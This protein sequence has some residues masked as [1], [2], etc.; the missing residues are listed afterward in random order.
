[1]TTTLFE[2]TLT[3]AR[4]LTVHE[5][6][7]LI[8]ALAEVLAAQPSPAAP[9]ATLVRLEAFRREMESLGPDAPN[10][11]AALEADRQTRQTTLEG[12]PHVHA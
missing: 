2:Q 1:M 4:Q 8:G 7:R 5:Q 11:G 12:E 6:A 10:F 3:L 9:N